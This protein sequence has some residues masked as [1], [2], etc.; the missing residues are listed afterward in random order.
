MFAIGTL[1]LVFSRYIRYQGFPMD[2]PMFV[3]LGLFFGPLAYLA[4]SFLVGAMAT[5][6]GGAGADADG[7]REARADSSEGSADSGE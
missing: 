1:L 6:E 3:L 7:N 4:G 2:V 5:L